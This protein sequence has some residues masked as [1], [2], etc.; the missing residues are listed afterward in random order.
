MRLLQHLKFPILTLFAA[1]L[2]LAPSGASAAPTRQDDTD[3]G[4]Q[5]NLPVYKW[6]DESVPERGIIFAIHGATLYAR[7][8]EAAARHFAEQGYPVYA[9]DLRGFGRWRSEGEKFADGDRKVHYQKAEDDI[10]AVLKKVREAEP[11]QKIYCLGESLGANLA[12]WVGSTHPELTDGLVLVSPCIKSYVHPGPRMFLTSFKGFLDP[13]VP[14]H[15]SGSIRSYLSD[16]RKIT[17]EYLHDPGIYHDLTAVDL[18]KS[19]KTNTL[20][21][22]DKDKIPEN[23]PILIVAG[24]VDKVY[25]TSAVPEFA[26]EMGSKQKTIEIVPNKGHLLIEYDLVG[27]EILG[28]I[29]SWLN[30][31]NVAD[32][33]TAHTADASINRE[34]ANAN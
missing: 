11:K 20:A 28:V 5:L 34:P 8:F 3:I 33:V 10:V 12:V 4:K 14:L 9:V 32:S 17:E 31:A 16:D 27:P 6:S 30:K 1:G 18:I 13:D 21:L 25:K 2:L 24:E 19:I 22:M 29:D 15:L 7:R 26:E 23:M